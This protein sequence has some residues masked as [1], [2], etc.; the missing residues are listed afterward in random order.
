MTGGVID[1]P[2][3]HAVRAA[4]K[5]GWTEIKLEWGQYRGL[6]PGGNCGVT[7]SVYTPLGEND[8]QSMAREFLAAMVQRNGPFIEEEWTSEQFREKARARRDALAREA[9]HQADMLIKALEE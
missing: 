5:A 9:V 3:P 1:R 7:A 6:P 2:L 4:I 8:R